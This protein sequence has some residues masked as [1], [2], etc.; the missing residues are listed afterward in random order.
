MFGEKRRKPRTSREVLETHMSVDKTKLGSLQLSPVQW[1][2]YH[3]RTKVKVIL[4]IEGVDGERE[5]S[6]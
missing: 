5:K 4:A 6:D 2:K 3:S 1:T